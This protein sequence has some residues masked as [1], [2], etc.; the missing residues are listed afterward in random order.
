MAHGQRYYAIAV[1]YK[2]ENDDDWFG[3]KLFRGNET[4]VTAEL[5]EYQFQIGVKAKRIKFKITASCPGLL[6]DHIGIVYQPKRV[7]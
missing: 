5:R 1:S 4:D 6:I 3:P 7:K 2:T